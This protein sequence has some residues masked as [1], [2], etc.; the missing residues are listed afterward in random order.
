V[1]TKSHAARAERA[2]TPRRH[3]GPRTQGPDLVCNANAADVSGDEEEQTE[4]ADRKRETAA[5]RGRRRHGTVE[6]TVLDE[7]SAYAG[8]TFKRQRHRVTHVCPVAQ[9]GLDFADRVR[10]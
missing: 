1:P 6:V 7:D 10:G 9:R 4:A 3:P 5:D 8:V 2:G